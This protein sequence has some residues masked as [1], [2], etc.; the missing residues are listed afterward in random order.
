[1]IAEML[2]ARAEHEARV[3]GAQPARPDATGCGRCP[4]AGRCEE[5]WAALEHGSMER[6]GWGVAIHGRV[7]D[8]A[9]SN[10]ER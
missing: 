1:M 3:P 9:V 2:R 4:W 5:A 8:G 6:L 7:S 10:N